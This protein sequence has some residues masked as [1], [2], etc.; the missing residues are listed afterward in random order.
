[1][2]SLEQLQ[3][4]ILAKLK[5]DATLMGMVTGVFDDVPQGQSFPFIQVGTATETPRN[6]FGRKGREATITLDIFS[7]YQG[8]KEALQIYSR[9]DE[10]LDGEPLTLQSYQLVFLQ[11]DGMNTILGPDGITRHIPARYRAFVQE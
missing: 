5:G 9:V 2:N 1:M 7:R 10:L 11:N 3:P 6:T 4:A 8:F